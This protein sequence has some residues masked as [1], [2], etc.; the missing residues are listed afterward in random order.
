MEFQRRLGAGRLAEIVGAAALPTDRFMRTLGLYRQAAASFAHLSAADAGLARGLCRGRQRLSRDPERAAAARV[1]DPAACMQI[2]PWT[3]ADSLVWLRL[4]A[5]DLGTN[6]RDELLRARLSTRL[7]DQQI[8]DI[9]PDYPDDAPITLAAA[10]ARPR[11]GGAGGGRLPPVRRRLERLGRWRAAGPGRGAPLL[12]NDPHLGLQAPGVWYLAHLKAPDCE[13]IGATLPGVPAVVLGHNGKVAWGF[14][15][16]GA[17]VEDLFIE[18]LDPGRSRPLSDPGRLGAVHGPRRGHPGQGGAAGHHHRARDPARPGALGPAAGRGDAVRRGSRAGARLDRARRGRPHRRCAAGA[19]PGA[20]LAGLRRR[21]R[22]RSAR[23]CR[24]S[25]T[26]T[27]AGHIGFIAPG[28]VPV[29]RQ[30]DGRWPVPGW[31]G[32]YDWQ[33]WIPFEDA[34][35]GARP[36]GRPAVQ[37]QQPGRAGGLPLSADRRL[38]GALPGAP[39]GRAARRAAT[40]TS[41][42]FAAIQAD[43][44]SP[45]AEDLLPI[46]LEAEPASPAAAAAI[47]ELRAW[48]RVMRPDGRAP[49]AVRGLV[50]RA[51]APDPGRRAGPAVP[52][53]LGRP[54][55]SSWSRS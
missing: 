47:R 13:L 10:D 45:L 26:P 49:L 2:E 11:A 8:A 20:R 3:P 28:R 7:T 1:P 9:W 15:N 16:T 50:P 21:R 51:V 24:T 38:G 5:L 43:Q 14:T 17:D 30:G 34:A 27:P 39:A 4:M 23:R 32:D 19:R 52:R 31:S 29:R 42:S 18:R 46:M 53:L 41:A 40:T 37:R 35:A 25:S 48:D 44:H 33:G 22:G 12:A 54:A 55:A 6:Y 36:A